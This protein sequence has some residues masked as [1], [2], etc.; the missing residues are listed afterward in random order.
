MGLGKEMVGAVLASFLASALM[1]VPAASV[2]REVADMVT[3]SCS[4]RKASSS[5]GVSGHRAGSSESGSPKSAV[6]MRRLSVLL[7]FLHVS[8]SS[9][10][11]AWA[12]TTGPQRKA[13]EVAPFAFGQ[14]GGQF[15]V[16]DRRR[17]AWPRRR[18][19]RP[20]SGGFGSVRCR[21]G[22]RAPLPRRGSRPGSV[23]SGKVIG[24][25]L[26]S[27]GG[28]LGY[29]GFRPAFG[30]GRGGRVRRGPS[31]VHR[32]VCAFERDGGGRLPAARRARPA[33]AAARPSGHAEST[34]CPT[35]PRPRLRGRR[36]HGRRRSALRGPP[37]RGS[38][39]YTDSPDCR[40]PPLGADAQ[41]CSDTGFDLRQ[42][43]ARTPS[44]RRHVRGGPGRRP[45]VA[46]AV[47]SPR[48]SDQPRDRW[49]Q[50]CWLVK[51]G[52]GWR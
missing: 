29:R 51:T 50:I 3:F 39:P 11:C 37:R 32:V 49:L 14:G 8:D 52:A 33:V 10:L 30:A 28:T 5:S 13:E 36:H 23:S 15:R 19:P 31:G 21:P 46:L 16:G 35:P 24:V 26:P 25:F 2:V 43:P 48:V 18:G 20:R 1:A 42:W 40:P 38:P 7:L 47:A 4:R 22:G 17:A 45:M 9:A 44:G 27:C 6:R 12:L 41:H 34:W